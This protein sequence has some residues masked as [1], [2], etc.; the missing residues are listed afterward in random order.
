MEFRLVPLAKVLDD[1]P[2]T[3]EGKYGSFGYE[4]LSV[5]DGGEVAFIS[6]ITNLPILQVEGIFVESP[7]GGRAVAVDLWPIPGDLTQ[8][9]V[10]VSQACQPN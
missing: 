1:A 10:P 4:G 8:R 7:S 9:L 3:G 5:N 2:G 6:P